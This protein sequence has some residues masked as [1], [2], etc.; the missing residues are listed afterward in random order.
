MYEQK[1]LELQEANALKM[2]IENGYAINWVGHN[3]QKFSKK[4]NQASEL[5]ELIGICDIL[6]TDESS[7]AWDFLYRQADVIFYKPKSKWLNDDA[8]L[9]QLI[10]E[11]K[12][13]LEERIRSILSKSDKGGVIN[14]AKYRDHNNSERTLKLAYK[15]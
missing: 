2:L 3:M 9:V 14:F 5:N 12:E 7:V 4:N 8:R 11:N 6:I 15:K 1:K 10:V 13:S